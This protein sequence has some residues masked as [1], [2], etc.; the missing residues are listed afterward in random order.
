MEIC[1]FGVFV[2]YL[3]ANERCQCYVHCS[4][5]RIV[6]STF[7]QSLWLTVTWYLLSFLFFS[8]LFKDETIK[9]V[10]I[11]NNERQKKTHTESHFFLYAKSFLLN[12]IW[13]I[14]LFHSIWFKYV[15]IAFVFVFFLVSVSDMVSVFW[16][17]WVLLFF[18]FCCSSV[19]CVC[20]S[21]FVACLSSFRSLKNYYI[22]LQHKTIVTSS[23]SVWFSREKKNS[24]SMRE[25]GISDNEIIMQ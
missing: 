22:D 24:W 2:F 20:L 17:R 4:I 3:Y 7:G 18:S 5:Q 6:W 11:N 21:F 8:F 10:C 13:N 25:R 19:Y 12:L 15:A 14:F 23:H 1:R 9:M 16:N